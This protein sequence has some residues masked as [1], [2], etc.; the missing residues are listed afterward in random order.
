MTKTDFDQNRTDFDQWYK[1]KQELISNMSLGQVKVE[2]ISLK[3]TLEG[4]HSLMGEDMTNARRKY[5]KGRRKFVTQLLAYTK[6]RIKLFNVITHNGT[7]HN[8][9]LKF[10]QVACDYLP[11]KTFQLLYGLAMTDIERN[12]IVI[13]EVKDF[14]A[15]YDRSIT[16]ICT[17]EVCYCNNK[18]VCLDQRW[19]K[20]EL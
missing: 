13:D 17:K 12:Q 16:P 6:E 1:E 15:E 5:L 8:V 3:A 18:G 10:L 11:Q 9:A 14:M 4:L 20:N 7:P 19:K 2:R